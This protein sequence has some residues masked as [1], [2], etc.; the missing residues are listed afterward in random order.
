VTLTPE[1]EFRENA[2]P[3]QVKCIEK[4]SAFASIAA[5]GGTN[6]DGSRWR[7]PIDQAVRFIES[8]RFRFFVDVGHGPV[9][10]MVDITDA[11]R[12]FVRTVGDQT[13]ENNLLSLP[14]CEPL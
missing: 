1:V 10:L 3:I 13:T 14:R 6:G 9:D 2:V 5:L 4:P 7:L 11:G 12:K 8:G